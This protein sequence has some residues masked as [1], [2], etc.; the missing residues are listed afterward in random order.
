M[1]EPI[2]TLNLHRSTAMLALSLMRK[3]PIEQAENEYGE[4]FHAIAQAEQAQRLGE[5]QQLVAQ[6]KE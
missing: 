2:Y 5:A 6:Q 4:L 1:N 3:L